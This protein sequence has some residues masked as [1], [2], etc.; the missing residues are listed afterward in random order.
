MVNIPFFDKLFKKEQPRNLT[1]G[2]LYIAV[3][4]GTEVLKGLLCK[5]TESGVEIIKSSRVWQQHHAM[6]SGIIQNIETVTD[7]LQLVYNDLVSDLVKAGATVEQLPRYIILGIAGEMVS[8]EPVMVT[9]DRENN[10]TLEITEDE[11]ESIISNV[12]ENV[13]LSGIDDLSRRLNVSREDVVPLHVDLTAVE[14]GAVRVSRMA[15]LRGKLMKLYFNAVFA[16]YTFVEAIISVIKRLNLEVIS[17]VAQPF[18]IAKAFKGADSIE[19]DGIFIDVGGGTSDIAVV[20][21]GTLVNSYMFAFGGRIFTESIAKSMNLEYRFA[22]KRKIKYSE[23]SLEKTI[24]KEVKAIVA[25]DASL[26][27][28]GVRIALSQFTDIE[29]MPSD[30]YLCG[31]GSLL[32]D[33]KEIILTYPWKKYIPF[34]KHPKAVIITP[35][36]LSDCIDKTEKL[37]SAIDVTPVAIARYAWDIYKNPQN[38]LSMKM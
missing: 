18:S 15:G 27:A 9:Y 11:E 26:W 2:D 37:K 38:H 8:G 34:I 4:I 24:A 7:N 31:G 28:D 1:L 21:K 6:R 33:I 17:I 5:V 13:I 19:F 14:I 29:Q 10:A 36:A 3:D 32:P 35:V 12:R 20:Q 16:P 25:E 23:G 30:I 22:E